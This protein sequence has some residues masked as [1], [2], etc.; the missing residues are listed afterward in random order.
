MV[1]KERCQKTREDEEQGRNAVLFIVFS[2]YREEHS[3]QTPVF[4][5]HFFM[6]QNQTSSSSSSSAK[7]QPMTLMTPL[8]LETPQFSKHPTLHLQQIYTANGKSQIFVTAS[9]IR[10]GTSAFVSGACADADCV[11]LLSDLQNAHR[12]HRPHTTSPAEEDVG[13]K[14]LDVMTL[15]GSCIV[16]TKQL[17]S[18]TPDSRRTDSHKRRL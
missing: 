18:N 6:H 17:I 10:S 5:L 9:L 13:V 11:P 15:T 2:I 1:E 4:L 3:P 14:R 7:L 8:R 16:G 12:Q